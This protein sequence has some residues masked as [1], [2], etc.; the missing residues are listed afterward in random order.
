MVTKRVVNACVSSRLNKSNTDEVLM[1]YYHDYNPQQLF[2]RTFYSF[3]RHN[4]IHV[5]LVG[6]ETKAHKYIKHRVK[7]V[8]DNDMN[9]LSKSFRFVM[10]TAQKTKLN[11]GG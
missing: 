4:F 5:Y 11:D 2:T 6:Q 7:N 9:S 3:A 1:Y 8:N 10:I